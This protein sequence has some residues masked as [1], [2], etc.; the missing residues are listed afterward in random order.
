MTKTWH[1]R[2]WI[3]A[4][5]SPMTEG[6]IQVQLHTSDG[7]QNWEVAADGEVTT[8]A[9]ADCGDC[10]EANPSVYKYKSENPR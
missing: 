5:T 1:A 2:L 9:V 4:I 6:E 10:V 3:G 8:M 7:K